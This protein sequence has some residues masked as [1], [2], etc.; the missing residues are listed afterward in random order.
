MDDRAGAEE[1]KTLEKGMI[2][3]VEK[4]SGH[5]ENHPVVASH[6]SAEKSQANPQDDDADVLNAMVG[7]QAFQ[8]VLAN[9]KGDTQ[10]ARQNPQCQQGHAPPKRRMRNQRSNA[11]DAVNPHLD[12]N[13][14]HQGGHV[15][16]SA[17]MGTGKPDV[18]RHDAGLQTKTHQGQ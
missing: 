10:D 9:G 5:T 18:K 13:S 15:T 14:R 8:V 16:G 1:Q 7:E 12:N 17:G 6:S 2:P 11:K 4:S 3:D